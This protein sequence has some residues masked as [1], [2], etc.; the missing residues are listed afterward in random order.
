[1][2]RSVP[3]EGISNAN[4]VDSKS[5]GG[6]K[7]NRNWKGKAKQNINLKKKEEQGEPYLLCVR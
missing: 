7:N 6:N 4:V 5:G 3:Q 2:P 1:V